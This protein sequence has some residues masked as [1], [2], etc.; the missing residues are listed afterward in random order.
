MIL[1]K[2]KEKGFFTKGVYLT[3]HDWSKKWPFD[4]ASWPKELFRNSP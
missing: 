2:G 1:R 4:A 3:V